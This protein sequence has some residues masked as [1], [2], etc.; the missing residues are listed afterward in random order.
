MSNDGA[1]SYAGILF[2][3]AQEAETLGLHGSALQQMGPVAPPCLA[4]PYRE[5]RE[6]L[7][8]AAAKLYAAFGQEHGREA[9]EQFIAK[10]RPFQVMIDSV[11]ALIGSYSDAPPAWQPEAY[12]DT[13][14]SEGTTER[15]PLGRLR[16]LGQTDVEIIARTRKL[17][18]EGLWR[19]EF[20][21][22][23]PAVVKAT[24]AV[25]AQG[26]WRGLWSSAGAIWGI[27]KRWS[28]PI[29]IALEVGPI[30]VN[31]FTSGPETS[32]A[33]SMMG[34]IGSHLKDFVHD[35]W[36][37][38]AQQW[39]AMIRIYRMSGGNP[40]LVRKMMEAWDPQQ[41]EKPLPP[42]SGDFDVFFLGDLLGIQIEHDRHSWIAIPILA[43]GSFGS[44]VAVGD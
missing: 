26:F 5:Y 24:E 1:Q 43:A 2:Q 20:A 28:L 8:E 7:I 10:T 27:A 34:E 16:G 17:L 30:L 38:V 21:A 6:K 15:S 37:R 14:S 9:L 39:Q 13:G 31:M 36:P 29:F 22:G 3:L 32:T 12:E 23:A 40:A 35:Y 33:R 42:Q 4:R 18:A 25:A 19:G 44:M 11:P 41:M